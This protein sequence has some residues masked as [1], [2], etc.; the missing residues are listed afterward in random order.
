MYSTGPVIV[1]R[2]ERSGCGVEAAGEDAAD[3]IGQPAEYLHQNQ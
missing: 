2:V 3:A 1:D